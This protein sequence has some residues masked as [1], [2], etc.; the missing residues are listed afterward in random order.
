MKTNV[1]V[2]AGVHESFSVF[3][4]VFVS[5]FLSLSMFVFVCVRVHLGARVCV[6]VSMSLCSYLYTCI[7]LCVLFDLESPRVCLFRCVCVHVCSKHLCMCVYLCVF[8]VPVVLAED[9]LSAVR[10]SITSTDGLVL[11]GADVIHV[12]TLRLKKKEIS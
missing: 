4:C 10:D 6:S 3:L 12:D 11:F 7:R 9:T 1:C 8:Y 2:S 5:V